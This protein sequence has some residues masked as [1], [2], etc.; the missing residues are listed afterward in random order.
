MRKIWPKYEASYLQGASPGFQVRKISN[1][2][3][4]WF[5]KVLIIVVSKK[6][7]IKKKKR[8]LKKNVMTNQIDKQK[9]G[10]EFY[11][12]LILRLINV[13]RLFICV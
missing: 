13:I 4:N 1:V 5:L 11:T 2:L 8:R 6:E 9:G 10:K 7:C 12:E 3:T